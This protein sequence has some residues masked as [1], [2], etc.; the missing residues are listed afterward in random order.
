MKTI[1]KIQEVSKEFKVK[2]RK[3]QALDNVN[4]EI[5]KGEIFG[6]IGPNGAGKT[7]LIRVLCGLLLPTK[8]GVYINGYNIIKDDSKLRS[9]IGLVSSDERSF[10]WHLTNKKNLE[11]FAALHNIKKRDFED[12]F[13]AVMELFKMRGKENLLFRYYSS[14]FKKRLALAR[15][16]L[17]N[18]QII[19]MDEATNN[20]DPIA[21]EELKTLVK[22]ELSVKQ[23]KT[24]FWATHRLEEAGQICDRVALLN[25][26]KIKFEGPIG[27]FKRI[28]GDLEM[29]TIDVFKYLVRA[30]K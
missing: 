30:N 19:F 8:G 21:S 26:G 24:I 9:S 15:A 11:F 17:H 6:I 16:L 2:K 27:D 22:N 7:T 1:I 25:C 12:R 14:G 3:I 10:F 18:P 13:S 23:K 4:L 5:K 29:S 20:L 28:K